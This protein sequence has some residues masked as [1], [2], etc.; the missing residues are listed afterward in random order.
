MVFSCLHGSCFSLLVPE[1]NIQDEKG[2]VGGDT[3][4]SPKVAPAQG[5]VMAIC[6]QSKARMRMKVFTTKKEREL[7]FSPVFGRLHWQP[8][9]PT[10]LK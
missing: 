1:K 6:D 3:P 9:R 2:P 5:V 4:T 10:N 7:T 8:C